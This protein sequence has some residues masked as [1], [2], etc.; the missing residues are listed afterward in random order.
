M[1]VLVGRG[2]PQIDPDVQVDHTYPYTSLQVS[3]DLSLP[4]ARPQVSPHL[5]YMYYR[6]IA[7]SFWH[8]EGK[9]TSELLGPLTL[10]FDMAT[11]AF[12]KTDM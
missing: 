5:Y 4:L 10:K 2:V 11:W 1:G 9:G 12:L 3:P 7:K 6:Y 8:F